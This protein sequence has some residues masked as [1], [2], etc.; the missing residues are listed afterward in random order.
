MCVIQATKK[1]LKSLI[2]EDKV[3]VAMCTLCKHSGDGKSRDC[4]KARHN[5]CNAEFSGFEAREQG[6]D[7]LF[8]TQDVAREF[9]PTAVTA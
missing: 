2:P 1:T 6:L 3:A 9:Q 4:S 5:R 7:H 8:A